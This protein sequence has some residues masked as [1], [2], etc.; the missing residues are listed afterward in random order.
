M[1]QNIR[2]PE[3]KI[4]FKA[5]YFLWI[6][7]VVFSILTITWSRFF[8][9]TDIRKYIWRSI[10]VDGES[11]EYTGKGIDLLIGFL[12]AMG[13][14]VVIYP[15]FF[16]AVVFTSG[17]LNGLLT[18]TGFVAF[19]FLSA[20][21]YYGAIR[22]RLARTNYRGI[23]FSLDGS[24]LAYA[25]LS[26]KQ[27]FLILVTLGFYVPHATNQGYAY[28]VSHLR[29][30]DQHFTYRNDGKLP[31]ASYVRFYLLSLFTF[32][33]A[34]FTYYWF[35][36][37]M[38]RHVVNNI[39]LGELRFE[40]RV[41]GGGLFKKSFANFFILLSSGGLLEPWVQIR[42]L[43]FACNTLY[44]SGDVDFSLI[45]QAE[46]SSNAASEGLA[47]ILGVE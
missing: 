34:W 6:K 32:G 3:L 11:F 19:V 28:I 5:F 47:E 1:S 17:Y 23:H 30:G 10:Q 38:T 9:K 27:F 37:S 26:L 15:A 33:L 36:A 46:G 31:V 22:Y 29:Y 7:H 25:I 12:K 14:L 42:N 18:F 16:I 13:F 4:Q 39:A 21:G 24:S 45:K 2:K 41:T 43:R 44:L 8:T 40:S 35:S 20:I